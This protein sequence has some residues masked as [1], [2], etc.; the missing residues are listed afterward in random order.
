MRILPETPGFSPA[1]KK[2]CSLD[3]AADRIG[4]VDDAEETPILRIEYLLP[5]S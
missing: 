3:L 5:G 2:S 4:I 1:W